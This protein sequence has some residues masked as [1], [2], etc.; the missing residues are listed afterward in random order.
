LV[1]LLPY[2]E[3]D[4]L[5]RSLWR[6]QP[7]F[8]PNPAEPPGVPIV[9]ALREERHGW[10]TASGNLQPV[11]GQ[12]RLKMFKCPSDTVDE[13]TTEGALMTIH[14]ANGYIVGLHPE[15]VGAPQFANALGRT[16]YT[17]VAGAAGN[18]D[19]PNFYS[20]WEGIM[21]NRSDLSLGQLTVQDGTSNT[22]LFGEGLGG[23]GVGPRVHVWSWMGVGAMGT[24]YGLGQGALPCD[25]D[26][27]P[28]LGATPADDQVGA[29]WFRFSSR[30][31]AG[32]NFAA[33]DGSVRQIRFG[34]TVYP[35]A[36]LSSDWAVLQQLAGR[37]DGLRADVSA[38]V[39]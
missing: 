29:H 7:N 39:E 17:G 6:T 19:A 3:Q 37:H 31:P 5:Y 34:R 24:G 4:G 26:V 25:E 27:P 14:V 13:D 8:P 11:T 22:L 38:I 33:A 15:D 1:T 18:A 28:P 23:N 12:M 20:T 32:V 10:W 35:S 21:C 36:S 2:M 9:L 16:S 30:H